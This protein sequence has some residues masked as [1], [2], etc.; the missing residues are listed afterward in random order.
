MK[1]IF[2]TNNQ[3][4]I[5]EIRAAIP[6]NYSLSGLQ[7]AGIFED[8]PET[9]DSIEGN[10]IQ[11][12]TYIFDRYSM[13][14]F[15]D[16][17]GLEVRALNNMPGVYSSRYAGP[18]GDAK[19]NITKLLLELQTKDDRFA[20][21]RTI[22]AYIDKGNIKT[23]EGIVEGNITIQEKGVKGFGYDP[24]FMPLGINKT[25]A[26]MSLIEKNKISHRSIALNKFIQFLNAG[27]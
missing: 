21:F 13:P 6:D 25:F 5:E 8:I 26:E 9:Q 27:I 15:A 1:L 14:C 17:T 20:C 3:H 11:K 12:A 10:A 18:D 22:I 24:V 23:F 7:E 16:D 4:K 19:R 2:A